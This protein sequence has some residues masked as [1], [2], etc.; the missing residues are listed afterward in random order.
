MR[1]FLPG[2]AALGALVIT[3]PAQASFAPEG[4]P[5]AVGAAQPYGVVPA[6]FNGDGRLDVATV[7]GTGSNLSVFLRGPSGFT[8]EAGSPFATGPGPGYGVAA[9]F[10]GDGL[11][12]VATQNFNNGT[13]GVLLRQ[14]GGGFAAGPTLSVGAGTGSVTAADFNGDGR[15]D[16]AA[17]SYT[18]SNILTYINNGTGFTQEGTNPTGATPRDVAAAD[19]N[20]DGQPDLA[21]SNLGAGSV[22]V[23]L[24]NPGNNGFASEAAAIPVGASPEG[25]KA[26]DFN[27]DGRPDIAVAVL[28]TNTVNVLLRNPAG[29][30]TAEAPIPVGAGALGLATADLNADGRPDLAVTSNTAG[31]VTALLRQAGGGFAADGA[32]LPAPGANGVAAGDFNG[33][34]KPDL[35]ASND[36]ANTLTVFLNTT[37]PAAPGPQPQPAGPPPPPVPGKSVVVRVVSGKVLIKYPA[38]KAPPGGSTTKFAPLTGAVNVPVGSVIDTTKGRIALTSAADTGG[39]KT[40]TAEFYDGIFQVKQSVPKKKPKKPAALITDLVMNEEIARS[41]CAPLKGARSAAADRKKGPN[42]VL[43][44]LW[45]SGK[46]K[47]RTDGKYSAATVRGTIWLVQDQCNGTLT[48]VK[49]GTVQVRDFKGKKTVS[50]KA[51]HTYLA[52]AARAAGKSKR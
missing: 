4:S 29:G 48:K 3:A 14:P 15:P 9:D 50:V 30:F 12:D 37:T 33:D 2:M 32:P 39:K 21:I 11:P 52:R 5:L 22:T 1:R 20:G 31:T 8:A 7:N 23:L 34:G 26:A 18:N 47:F 36:T 38:G 44:K 28:G 46:G 6:D 42:A 13:V 24:R 49:R 40:Q 45:G 19:F 27:G 16:I 35:A 43:G 10:N 25:I 17:P 51:G 41:Q